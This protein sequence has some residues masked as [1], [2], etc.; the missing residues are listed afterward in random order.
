MSTETQTDSQV[1]LFVVGVNKSGTSWLYHLL[2]EH[3]QINMS[4]QKE[5][6]YFGEEY[7]D[8]MDK[9]HSHFNFNDKFLYYGEATPTYYRNSEIAVQINEYNPEAKLIIIVRDPIKRFLS[10]FYF[11]KQI[12]RISEN[13]TLEEFLKGD[14]R[15]LLSDSHYEKTIPA[16]SCIFSSDK[17][18]LSSLEAVKK[19]PEGFWGELIEFLG[20]EPVPLPLPRD[21]SENPTGSR[22]FRIIYRATIQPIKRRNYALYQTMLKSR[23][24]RWTKLTLLKLTGLAQKEELSQELMLNLVDEFEPTYKYLKSLNINSVLQPSFDR[25]KDEHIS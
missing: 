13:T 25:N 7:P 9:Y 12:G 2:K 11:Q 6:Y 10:Q 24:L 15:F 20:V 14:T 3:P 22:W 1:N 4:D 23:A 8:A 21:R 5:L 16:F 18:F 19:N 17:L